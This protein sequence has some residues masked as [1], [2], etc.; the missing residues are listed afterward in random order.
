MR[1]IWFFWLIIALIIIIVIAIGISNKNEIKNGNSLPHGATN[2]VE[3]GDG[4]FEFNYKGKRFLYHSIGIADNRTESLAELGN[5]T[6]S[7]EK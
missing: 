4:W 2:I 6:T 3:V 7:Q 5:A 1:E